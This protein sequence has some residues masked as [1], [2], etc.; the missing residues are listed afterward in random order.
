M[1]PLT[2]EKKG[3]RNPAADA[4]KERL[5][6]LAAEEARLVKSVNESRLAEQSA[7]AAAEKAKGELS[8]TE[9]QIARRREEGERECAALEERRKAA[10]APIAEREAAA[11][12]ALSTATAMAEKAGVRMADAKA[13]EAQAKARQ[14][15]AEKSWDAMSRRGADLDTR[16][17][18]VKAS[19]EAVAQS[20]ASLDAG[21][22]NLAREKDAAAERAQEAMEAVRIGRE[23]NE[24]RSKRLDAEAKH[25]AQ[26]RIAIKDGYANL[27][28]ARK[29]ILGRDT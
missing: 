13:A 21:W 24:E 10:L 16:E 1:R 5:R 11:K 22:R 20:Q 8:V 9:A 4:A 19:E 15:E 7:K 28:I 6:L 27:A 29:R 17:A 12:K 23:A 14:E 25:N 2:P 3:N 26:E 18:Q